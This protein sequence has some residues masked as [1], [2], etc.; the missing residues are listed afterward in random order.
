MGVVAVS[1]SLHRNGR[2]HFDDLTGARA[3]SPSAFYSQSKFANVLFGLELHRRLRAADSPIRSLLAHPG[4]TATNLQTSGP[5][6]LVNLLGRIGNL[7][8]AQ[9]PA[10]GALPQL[11]AAT[12]PSAEGGRFIGPDGPFETRGHPKVV[13]PAATAQDPETA[14]R[15]WELSEK[16]TGVHYPLPTGSSA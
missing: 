11:Y 8:V 15:L 14:R 13:Q 4:Y 12:G 5:T 10:M 6:G 16:L 9:T 1:S 3:Y 7:L 2:V